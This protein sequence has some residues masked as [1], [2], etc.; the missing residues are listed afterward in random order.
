MIKKTTT[1]PRIRK[2]DKAKV[3]TSMSE[4]ADAVI[5]LADRQDKYQDHLTRL[6]NQQIK[7]QATF[8]NLI[9]VINLNSDM[10]K[11]LSL[12]IAKLKKE[13]KEQTEDTLLVIAN[14]S[15]SAIQKAS[16]VNAAIRILEN[17]YNNHTEEIAGIKSFATSLS[18]QSLDMQK[19]INQAHTLIER[20]CDKYY[21]IKF[22]NNLPFYKRIFKKI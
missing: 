22:R 15:A 17:Y 14:E 18:N 13:L 20:L 3:I 12:D 1:K 8:D 21:E 6:T 16:T 4:L 2:A 10:I 9:A 19:Q 7:T 11:P 5:L